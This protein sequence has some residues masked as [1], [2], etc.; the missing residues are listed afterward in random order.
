M[1]AI[2]LSK[3]Y[4]ARQPSGVSQGNNSG[5]SLEYPSILNNCIFTRIFL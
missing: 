4:L 1:Q 5:S 3:G 2:P